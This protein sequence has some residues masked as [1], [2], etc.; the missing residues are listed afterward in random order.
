MRPYVR[1]ANV[2]E[3]KLDLSD[4]K[5]MNFTPEEYETFRLDAGDILL[6]EGQ[7]PHLIGRPALFRNEIESCCFQKTLL[8]FRSVPGVLP[9]Y[10]LLV[11]RSYMHSG[12]F[13]RSSRITTNIGHLTQIRFLPIPFPLPTEREQIEIVERV[14]TLEGT[15]DDAELNVLFAT[16]AALRQSILT[17]PFSGKLVSQDPQDEPA[18]VLLERLRA[19]RTA[20]PERRA[21]NRRSA[22][23]QESAR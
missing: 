8:R 21:Y 10:A 3:D 2:L 14:R 19:D 11:F 16:S 22:R 17:L 1:V 12:R 13:K 18:S 9:E 23:M 15:M 6:N 5:W 20:A 4:V 7:A